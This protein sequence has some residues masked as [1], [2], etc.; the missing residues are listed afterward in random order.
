MT[1]RT[2]LEAT[3]ERVRARL[4]AERLLAE[5]RCQDVHGVRWDQPTVLRNVMTACESC[6]SWSQYAMK[7]LR[8]VM[9]DDA[10][11]PAHNERPLRR[12]VRRIAHECINRRNEWANSPIDGAVARAVAYQYVAGLL[13]RALDEAPPTP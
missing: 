7:K 8:N 6:H 2:P 13:I 10:V 5:I 9:T 1:V 11:A 4:A 3:A 12:A